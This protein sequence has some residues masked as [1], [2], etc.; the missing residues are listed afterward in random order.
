MAEKGASKVIE[1]TQYLKIVVGTIY[2][3]MKP[4]SDCFFIKCIL[5]F[6]SL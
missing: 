6:V 2:G 1:T 5:A 3:S 4:L